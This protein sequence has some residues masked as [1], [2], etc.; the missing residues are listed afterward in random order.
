MILRITKRSENEQKYI[1]RIEDEIWGVLSGR[2]LRSFLGK[3]N[4]LPEDGAQVRMEL[5]D[6]AFERFVDFLKEQF[7]AALFDY[8]GKQEHS[9][10]QAREYLK[11]QRLHPSILEELIT[12][13]RDLGY[14]CD[15]RFAE[16]FIRSCAMRGKSRKQCQAKLYECGISASTSKA[17]LD[18]YY[19]AED[20]DG[21]I[22]D[23]I[24][25]L[26]TRYSSLP[27]NKGREKIVA[28]LYRK[29]FE[30]Q[31]IMAIYDQFRRDKAE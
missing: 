18:D 31:R 29:G 11:K 4:A 27:E 12:A 19:R 30:L 14:V 8:L 3:D 20:T 6:E 22:L 10:R 17:Y 28:S 2:A 15:T 9:E 25:R 1:L 24:E 16:L 26:W 13:A 7:R 5:G 21:M 23:G